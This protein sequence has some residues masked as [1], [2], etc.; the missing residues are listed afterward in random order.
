LA[1]LEA[2]H[3]IEKIRVGFIAALSGIAFGMVV[4]IVYGLATK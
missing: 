4:V 1:D 2:R 3:R